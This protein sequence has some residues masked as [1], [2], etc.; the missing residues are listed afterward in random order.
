M[1][2]YL[3]ILLPLLLAVHGD[4]FAQSGSS[5]QAAGEPWRLSMTAFGPIK[6]GMTDS[7]VT[8]LLRGRVKAEG[9]VQGDC[10]HLNGVRDLSGVSLMIIGGKVVRIEIGLPKFYSLS[11]AGVGTTE[12]ELKRLYGP[13]LKIEPHRY[14][15]DRGNYLTLYSEDGQFG[16]RF[17]TA[18]GRVT[19]F[20]AG[21]RR[22]LHYIE[23]CS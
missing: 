8:E 21:P 13:K 22:H 7:Q 2:I 9:E 3:R 6:P 23:G 1:K 15:E 17:E 10:Y 4:L 20:Y 12:T 14:L 18:D 5:A 19:M 16:M 11:G